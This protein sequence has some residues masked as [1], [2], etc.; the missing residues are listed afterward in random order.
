M[1]KSAF[2]ICENNNLLFFGMCDNRTADQ[3]ICFPLPKRLAI[4]Y[5]CTDWFVSDLVE[6]PKIGFLMTWLK[7][8]QTNSNE[9]S[10]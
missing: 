4:F 3:R 10:D 6:S 1:R 7:F 2:S 8:H 9:S 5:G